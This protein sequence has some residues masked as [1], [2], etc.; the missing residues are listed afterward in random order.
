[1][2]EFVNA[3]ANLPFTVCIILLLALSSLEVIGMCFGL[4]LSGLLDQMIP[5]FDFDLD[6]DAEIDHPSL[7]LFLQWIPVGRVPSL[8]IIILFFLIFGLMGYALQLLSMKFLGQMSNI[9]MV[10]AIDF[11]ISF[12]L[13]SISSRALSRVIP[14]D[15]SSAVSNKSFEGKTAKITIGE[16]KWQQPAEAKL[17]DE[18]GRTHYIMVTPSSDS[19]TLKQGEEIVITEQFN[20]STWFAEKLS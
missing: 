9:W 17:L 12:P 6:V 8:V 1:M 20:S 11:V 14:G 7:H 5:D 18:H 10:S 3:S 15:E 16:A 4:G 13:L 2:L 19:Y